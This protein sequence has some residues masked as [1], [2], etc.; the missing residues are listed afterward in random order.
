MTTP[1]ASPTRGRAA[2]VAVVTLALVGTALAF[3]FGA[4]A[5]DRP[6]ARETDIRYLAVTGD[7]PT[8]RA[9]FDGAPPNGTPVQ[10]ALDTFAQQGFRVSQVTQSLIVSSNEASRW[11]ILLQRSK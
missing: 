1:H 9:W 4:R 8:A 11:T 6:P 5:E 7:G 3:A 2:L 10:E